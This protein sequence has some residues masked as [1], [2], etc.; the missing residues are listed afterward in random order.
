[1]TPQQSAPAANSHSVSVF[2]APSSS[3]SVASGRHDHPRPSL[4][5]SWTCYDG[6][7]RAS[8]QHRPACA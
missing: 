8:G 3:S 5:W 4:Q 2:C 6:P 7:L 1:V